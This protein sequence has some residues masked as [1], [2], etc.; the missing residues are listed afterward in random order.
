MFPGLHFV[1][2]WLFIIKRV[3]K[4][5]QYKPF[6]I[7]LSCIYQWYYKKKQSFLHISCCA[8]FNLEMLFN[9]TSKNISYHVN[10]TITKY[11]YKL[12]NVRSVTFDNTCNNL[13][14]FFF[15][16]NK[17]CLCHIN[18]ICLCHINKIC[19]TL[20]KFVSH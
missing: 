4:H 2:A 16:I 6:R 10:F 11:H 13:F 20:T 17:I 8:N 3:M 14:Q 1:L 9:K 7:Y 18:K 19:V 5:R 15:H 12:I